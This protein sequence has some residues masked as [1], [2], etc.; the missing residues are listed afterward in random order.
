MCIFIST[1]QVQLTPLSS[2]HEAYLPFMGTYG[3]GRKPN[4]CN[5][6]RKADLVSDQM[7][8]RNSNST[9]LG[10]LYPTMYFENRNRHT[11]CIQLHLPHFLTLRWLK[12]LQFIPMECKISNPLSPAKL[13]LWL[14]G[15]WRHSDPGCQKQSPTANFVCPTLAQRGSCRF[16]VGPAWAQRRA[17]LSG[18]VLV[19]S[20]E[21]SDSASAGLINDN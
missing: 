10:G 6:W 20:P 15:T 8:E 5:W 17:L 16:H 1:S 2:Q 19:S 14:L 4:S 18:M 3:A 9:A 7:G 21:Y 13:I 12:C 11:A